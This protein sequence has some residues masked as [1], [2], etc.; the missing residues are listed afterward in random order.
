V[1]TVLHPERFDPAGGQGGLIDCEH[2]ARYWWASQAVAGRKVLDAACGTGYG[3]AILA[4]AGAAEVVGVDLDPEAVAAADAA[5][6]RSVRILQGDVGR[7]PF[8]DAEF[9]VVVSFETIEHIQ[10]GDAAMREFRRVLRPDGVLILSSPNRGVYPTGNE[11]HVHELT[12]AE[13]QDAAS[14]MFANVRRWR[15]H[16]WVASTIDAMDDATPVLRR[17]TT[18][19]PDDEIFTLVVASNAEPPELPGLT[20][21]GEAF[22]VRWWQE[23]VDG[24]REQLAAQQHES[25]FLLERER[26]EHAE[27][28]SRLQEA[29]RRV[30]EAEQ[31]LAKVPGLLKRVSD[32]DEELERHANALV[33][34]R[35]GFER[36][37]SWRMTSPLRAV[38]RR[39]R[40]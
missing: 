32:L 4:A 3:S 20:V 35:A 27:T 14:A 33:E 40:R 30:L 25:A 7:L 15:Q 10:D 38:K 31:E 39:L 26:A 1:T 24:A 22:E 29:G 12:A 23:Q 5:T 34:M 9:D 11:H 19:A 18:L 21:L 36:S 13:L 6:G 37:I 2:H 17:R 16:A 8:E 28:R